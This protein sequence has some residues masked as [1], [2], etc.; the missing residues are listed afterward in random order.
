MA[1]CT[2]HQAEE[3]EGEGAPVIPVVAVKTAPVTRGNIDIVVTATGTTDAVRKEKVVAPIS[4]VLIALKVLE[5]TPVRKGDVVAVI[6][7]KETRAAITGAESLL[8]DAT[9]DRERAEARR[10]MELARR[11]ANNLEVRATT[12]AVV[13]SRSVTEG[14]LV[15]EGADLVTLV[16]L[17]TLDF[18][19]DVPLQDVDRVHRGQ[20]A[21]IA[22]QSL[23]G[24]RFNATVDAVNPRT[25]AQ[26]QTVRVRLA[27]AGLGSAR[28]LLRTDMGGVASIVTGV[29]PGVL[30]VPKA[31]V[32]RNDETDA[33]TVVIATPDSLSRV[34]PVVVGARTDST[35][36]VSGNGLAPGVRVIVEGNY[37]LADST[38]I[39]PAP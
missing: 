2:R 8:R 1:G 9:T 26:S 38:R 18:I 36:E 11:G 37:A 31:A 4:G 5:G 10:A 39:A 27:F 25:D 7:P 21:A 29:H 30:I 3:D 14:E 15:A 22:F 28:A 6:Q 16:D 13:A 35:A 19:A 34:V 24:R 20:R 23:P 33:C 32:L 17:G 12:D